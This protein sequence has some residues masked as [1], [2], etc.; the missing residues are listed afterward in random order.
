V[1]LLGNAL[2]DS[3]N[4]GK[5]QRTTV[6]TLLYLF[7]QLLNPAADFLLLLD[8]YLYFLHLR[9]GLHHL[10][11]NLQPKAIGCSLII[12]Y[13]IRFPSLQLSA[14]CRQ[15]RQVCTECCVCNFEGWLTDVR[16]QT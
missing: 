8:L 3:N 13:N 11:L 1:R 10:L 4:D 2:V 14:C 9:D 12:Q 7:A 5:R 15:L 16:M 6:V